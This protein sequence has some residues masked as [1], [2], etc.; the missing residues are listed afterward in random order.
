MKIGK[1]KRLS[2]IKKS[3]LLTKKS[4]N[5]RNIELIGLN[6]LDDKKIKE[7]S[8]ITLNKDIMKKIGN[9]KIWSIDDINK[10]ILDEINE[11]NKPN[12]LRK[13][14]SYIL[15]INNK[16]IGFISGRKNNLLLKPQTPY[17]LLLRMFIHQ[18]YSGKGYGKLILN[19]FINKYKSIIKYDLINKKY[20]NKIRLISDIDANNIASIKIHLSNQFIFITKIKYPSNKKLLRY[21]YTF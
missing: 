1:I 3:S 13:Y 21:T 10:Y 6:E 16:V 14:Y 17:D 2:S 12:I 5:M 20:H 4:V 11:I 19:L 8:E 9:G 15:L 18:H 7:L